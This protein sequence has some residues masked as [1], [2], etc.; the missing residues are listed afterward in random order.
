MTLY[1]VQERRGANG[2]YVATLDTDE[3]GMALAF[4][5]HATSATGRETR[6]LMVSGGKI[7]FKNTLIGIGGSSRYDKKLKRYNVR[8]WLTPKRYE[9]YTAERIMTMVVS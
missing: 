7:L 4:S 2:V 8:S 5:L 6:V 9:D 3:F 1:Q